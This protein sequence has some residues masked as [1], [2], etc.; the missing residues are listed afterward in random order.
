VLKTLL[1]EVGWTNH[2]D[3]LQDC[4]DLSVYVEK[5]TTSLERVFEEIE[6]EC[7]SRLGKDHARL[8]FFY[9]LFGEVFPFFSVLFRPCFLGRVITTPNPT[10]WLQ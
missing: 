6:R 1:K 2:G 3:S 9:K 5:I 7:S 10:F 4:R 8:D